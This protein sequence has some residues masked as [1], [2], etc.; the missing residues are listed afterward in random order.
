MDITQCGM[1]I[2]KFVKDLNKILLHKNLSYY[3]VSINLVPAKKV[4]KIVVNVVKSGSFGVVVSFC[5]VFQLNLKPNNQVK[6]IYS[7]NGVE[8]R[9]RDMFFDVPI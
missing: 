9:L 3:D 6:Q 2:S 5:C 8:K 7:L 4:S 1:S